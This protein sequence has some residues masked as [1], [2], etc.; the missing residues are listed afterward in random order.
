ME[1]TVGDPFSLS[2]AVSGGTP[3]DKPAIYTYQWFKDG[4]AIPGSFSETLTIASL[5]ASDSGTYY[6]H[7]AA[8]LGGGT[9]SHELTLTVVT[10]TP[11]DSGGGGC[12]SPDSESGMATTGDSDDAALEAEEEEVAEEE[13]GELDRIDLVRL[14]CLHQYVFYR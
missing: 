4:N 14:S 8:A 1:M 13:D 11:P 7:V 5:A 2:I 6:C 10:P 9:Y 3:V 12:G